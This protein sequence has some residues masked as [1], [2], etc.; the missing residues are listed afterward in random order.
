L[1]CQL[2]QSECPSALEF[3]V[4]TSSTEAI[5]SLGERV[6]G[7]VFTEADWSNLDGPLVPYQKSQISAETAA[8]TFMEE[9]VVG[10]P[11]SPR[12]RPLGIE[13]GKSVGTVLTAIE[14]AGIEDNTIV[15][16]AADGGPPMS[17][18]LDAAMRPFPRGEKIESGG[19]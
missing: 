19:G 10:H 16:D 17:T 18:W 5:D 11:R 15:V 4:Q 14:E 1:D 13:H 2:H 3:D 6:A 12:D 8:W 7:R 9:L